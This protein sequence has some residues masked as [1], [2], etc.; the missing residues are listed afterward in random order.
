MDGHGG[1]IPTRFGFPMHKV[2]KFFLPVVVT[3]S[4]MSPTSENSAAIALGDQNESV[5]NV[6]PVKFMKVPKSWKVV[7]WERAVGVARVYQH[8]DLLPPNDKAALIAIIYRG[9]PE[10]E[11]DGKIFRGILDANAH[12]Q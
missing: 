11:E 12:L 4:I 10:K 9:L 1:T 5:R 7:K 6:G 3:L 8:T 2:I